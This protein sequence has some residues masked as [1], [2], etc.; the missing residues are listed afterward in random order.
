MGSFL[1]EVEPELG[2]LVVEF[3]SRELLG[4][5]RPIL[6]LWVSEKQTQSQEFLMVSSGES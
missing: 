6:L 1:E 3:S 2:L 5:N 4:S